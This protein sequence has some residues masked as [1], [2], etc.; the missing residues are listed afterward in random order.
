[1]RGLPHIRRKKG[2]SLEDDL[3]CQLHVELLP[4]TEAGSAVEVAN[5]VTH[6]TESRACGA[7]A[8]YCSATT[9]HRPGPGGQIDPVIEVKHIGLHADSDSLGNGKALEY[10]QVYVSITRGIKLVA[11]EIAD[12]ARCRYS[13][14]S[15]IPP[16]RPSIRG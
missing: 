11:R 4:G 8:V 14:C 2:R 5:R 12:S 3:H 16:L 7:D 15:R 1:M 6:F 13:E 10:G 9:T